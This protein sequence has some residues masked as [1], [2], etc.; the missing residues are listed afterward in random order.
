MAR[1]LITQS[2]DWVGPA[3]VQA[4]RTNGDEV[5]GDDG[6]LTSSEADKR[7]RQYGEVDVL[8]AH[9]AVAAPSTKVSDVTDDE[10]RAVFSRLVDPLPRLMRIFL[11]SM[12]Q[13]KAGKVI[14]IGSAAPLRGLKR[15]STYSSAR[16]AQVAYVRA[17][18]TEVA[19]QNV[20]V[21]LIAPNFID[22]P[23]YFPPDVQ[24]LEAFQQRLKSDV[25]AG[26]MGRPEELAAFAVFLASA[27]AGFF[28][29]QTFPFSGGWAT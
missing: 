22:H 27:Q 2:A 20:Q 18:G 13:R 4:F 24:A 7:L 16:G 17:V 19:A 1:V 10:W 28:A 14:V 15:A 5:I 11:P 26:R 21:N 3:L 29:G 25:P 12:A 8:V 23:L 6:D 9:L